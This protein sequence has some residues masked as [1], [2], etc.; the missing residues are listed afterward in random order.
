M[1]PVALSEEDLALLIEEQFDRDKVELSAGVKRLY[2]AGYDIEDFSRRAARA[3]LD[4][5]SPQ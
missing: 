5:F 2:Y 1:R 4:R 3:I